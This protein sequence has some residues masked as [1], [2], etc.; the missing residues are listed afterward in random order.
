M[1]EKQIKDMLESQY[2]LLKKY[3]YKENSQILFNLIRMKERTRMYSYRNTLYL[4]VKKFVDAYIRSVDTEDYGYDNIILKK[5]VEAVSVLDIQQQKSVF[6]LARRL[7]I[8]R[9][10][11]VEELTYL[12]EELEHK[13]KWVEGKYGRAVVLWMSHRWWALLAT[14]LGYAI[15]LFLLLLPTPFSYPALFQIEY[16]TYSNIFLLNHGMNILCLMTGNDSISPAV[17]P[18]NVFGVVL[19]VLGILLYY[20]ILVN[21]VQRKLSN[22]ITLK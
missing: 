21:F 18:L 8:V 5:I 3:Q 11:D 13:V 6:L 22:Y 14:Y 7:M 16:K 4:D 12:I 10:Y 9:G 19:Y 2:N 15:L 20:L 1:D 17:I